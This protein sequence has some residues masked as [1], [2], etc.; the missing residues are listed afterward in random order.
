MRQQMEA[1]R[2]AQKKMT[3]EQDRLKNR[4]KEKEKEFAKKK[5]NCSS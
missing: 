4:L 2:A 5:S 3:Q 1:L